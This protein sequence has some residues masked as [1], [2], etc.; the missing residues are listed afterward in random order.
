MEPQRDNFYILMVS[1]SIRKEIFISVIGMLQPFKSFQVTVNLLR[2][3]EVQEVEMVNL[4]SPGMSLLTQTT[5]YTFR[6]METIGF[7]F[8]RMTEPF[9]ANGEPLVMEMDS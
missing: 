2:D 5:M 3:G 1:P 7:K 8:L 6:I 4:F 9:L